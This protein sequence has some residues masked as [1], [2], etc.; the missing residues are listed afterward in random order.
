MGFDFYS[1]KKPHL[2][3]AYEVGKVLGTGNFAEVHECRRKSDGVQC[4]VKVIDK[5]KAGTLEAIQDEIAIMEAINHE[6]VV[7]LIEVFDEKA[8]INVRRRAAPHRAAR[9]PPPRR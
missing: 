1:K 8:K 2:T 9:N 7:K 3:S 6:N 5:V 4:A